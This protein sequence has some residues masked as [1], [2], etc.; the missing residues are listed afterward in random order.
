MIG[1]V[2]IGYT[3]KPKHFSTSKAWQS[4]D[5]CVQIESFSSGMFDV[6]ERSWFLAMIQVL[7]Y[8]FTLRTLSVLLY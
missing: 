8:M 3:A 2:D 5:H 6:G 1:L 7:A 4:N